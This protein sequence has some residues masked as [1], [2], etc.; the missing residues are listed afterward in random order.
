VTGT[1]FW[2]RGPDPTMVLPAGTTVPPL[3]YLL[4]LLAAVAAV[5]WALSHREPPVTAAT[6]LALAPWM[7]AGATTYVTYQLELVPAAIAPFTGSPAV[8]ATAF[9]AAGT[10]WLLADHLTTQPWGALAVAGA[11]ATV[12]STIAAVLSADAL[13]PLVP[14][15]ALLAAVAVALGY[16]WI[17]TTRAPTLAATGPAGALVVFGQAL[18]GFTT[19]LGVAHLGFGE[20]TPLSRLLIEAMANYPAPLV[21]AG[22]LF[23]LV[24]LALGVGVVWLLAP[25]VD[26]RPRE[27]YLLLALVAAVGLGPGAHNLLLFTVTA[28]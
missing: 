10:V 18:D 16:R 28:P 24:K 2:S 23:C 14:A 26:R 11:L 8:Y 25:T 12:P 15:A 1:V 6:V 3:P 17:A 20:Q 21:G 27:G 22:W 9:V 19:T 13:T 7:V 5:A 4:V